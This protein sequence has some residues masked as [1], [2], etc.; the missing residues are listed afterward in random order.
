[1][2][3]KSRNG[4]NKKRTGQERLAILFTAEHCL[5]DQ[6]FIIQR[7]CENE[8]LHRSPVHIS[9]VVGYNCG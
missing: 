3:G 5:V 2:A 7:P 8:I 1:M 9:S 4:C 6:K